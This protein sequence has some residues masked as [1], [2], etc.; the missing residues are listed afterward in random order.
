MSPPPFWFCAE[1][2]LVRMVLMLN[3]W[4]I[5]GLALVTGVIHPGPVVR[6]QWNGEVAGLG[7]TGENYP[8]PSVVLPRW[9]AWF[10][11]PDEPGP[12]PAYEPAIMAIYVRWGWWVTVWWNWSFRN[13]A[14]GWLYPFRRVWPLEDVPRNEQLRQVK[15]GIGYGWK[16]Y[17][18]WRAEAVAPHGEVA[19][20]YYVVP[21]F[22]NSEA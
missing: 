20:R 1:V 18:D 16:A 5:V 6:G 22:F 15:C 13:I 2:S 19:P 21:S 14:H 9:L 17:R 12:F 4:W 11:T 3:A 7:E 10:D 8:F